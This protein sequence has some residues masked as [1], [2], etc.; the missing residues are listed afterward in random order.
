MTAD[1]LRVFLAWCSVINIGVLI[2]WLLWFQL[3]HDFVYRVHGQGFNLSAERFDA[4]HYSGM[5]FYKVCIFLF[6]IVPYLVLRLVI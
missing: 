6:N 2:F 3:A 5:L 4:L 1:A